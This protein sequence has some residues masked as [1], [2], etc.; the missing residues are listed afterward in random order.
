MI[1][2]MTVIIDLIIS[3]KI[4][5]QLSI[6]IVIQSILEFSSFNAKSIHEPRKQP[7]VI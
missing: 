2:P 6:D 3:Q 4:G 1:T 5:Q 7:T